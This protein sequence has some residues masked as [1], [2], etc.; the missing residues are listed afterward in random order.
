MM[1]FAPLNPSYATA[2]SPERHQI[3]LPKQAIP[4]LGAIAAIV[5]TAVDW[6]EI[7]RSR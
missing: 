2:R 4:G 7:E 5:T 1:G 3:A 6:K